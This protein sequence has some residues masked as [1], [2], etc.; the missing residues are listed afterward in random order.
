MK[1]NIIDFH[2]SLSIS[3]ASYFPMLT[4][5]SFKDSAIMLSSEILISS[6]FSCGILLDF[7]FLTRR[8][9]ISFQPC[10]MSFDCAQSS[11][12]LQKNID[13]ALRISESTLLR[14][15]LYFHQWLWALYLIARFLKKFLCFI[16]FLMYVRTSME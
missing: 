16:S 14:S 3:K 9:L 15:S 10:R 13:L 7:L 5:K 1:V 2:I 4:K 8:L 12:L 6:I 11:I